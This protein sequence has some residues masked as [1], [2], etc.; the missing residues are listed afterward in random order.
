MPSKK[1]QKK[2]SENQEKKVSEIQEKTES[3]NKMIRD[4]NLTACLEGEKKVIMGTQPGVS[5]GDAPY[6]S[7]RRYVHRGD[8]FPVLL[9]LLVTQPMEEN[10]P[11]KLIHAGKS[12]L[13][14]QRAVEAGY[15][16]ITNVVTDQDLL[17]ALDLVY[18]LRGISQPA[19]SFNFQSHPALLQNRAK[20]QDLKQLMG[21]LGPDELALISGR[22]KRGKKPRGSSGG[23][24]SGGGKGGGASQVVTLNSADFESKVM[25]SKDDWLIAFT[26][27][28]CG[29]CVKLLPMWEDAAEQLKGDFKLGWVDATQEPG[30]AQQYQVQGYPTSKLF[31]L[32][33]GRKVASESVEKLDLTRF[34][35]SLRAVEL[36]ELA[37]GSNEPNVAVRLKLLHSVCLI[38]GSALGVKV[39]EWREGGGGGGS[40]RGGTSPAAAIGSPMGGMS[41]FRIYIKLL[42][43]GIT[44]TVESRLSDTISTVKSKIQKEECI[45]PDQQHLIFAGKTLEDCERTLA[46]YDVQPESTLH[47]VVQRGPSQAHVLREC[48]APRVADRIILAFPAEDK[49][50]VPASVRPGTSACAPWDVCCARASRARPACAREAADVPAVL[51]I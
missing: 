33:D 10:A 7:Y 13:N 42:R 47:L 28:E 38:L 41:T 40:S 8:L 30:L 22:S 2:V 16:N 19:G 36:A 12:K 50:Q 46:H 24:K 45:S 6:E 37:E 4:R 25:E 34:K 5:P 1:K 35:A 23:G 9:G 15:C 20:K 14:I 51:T 29:H 49:L 39:G 44:I 48:C 26:K 32:K 43:T 17:G 21:K 18:N 27:P 31:T 11:L 3:E